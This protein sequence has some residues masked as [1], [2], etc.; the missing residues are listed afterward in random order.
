MLTLARKNVNNKN[1]AGLLHCS[2]LKS[3]IVIVK[4][5]LLVTHIALL[6]PNVVNYTHTCLVATSRYMYS[7][8]N[9]I[10]SQ[11][12]IWR[13]SIVS[14]APVTGLVETFSVGLADTCFNYPLVTLYYAIVRPYLRN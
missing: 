13:Q 1:Y 10:K 2:S 11:K 8:K 14:V 6:R 5:A 7:L 12:E 9:E 4:Y 3:I